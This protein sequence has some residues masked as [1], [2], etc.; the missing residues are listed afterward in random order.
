NG[1]AVNKA[2]GVS[3]DVLRGTFNPIPNVPPANF[4]GRL[5]TLPHFIVLNAA[6]RSSRL[7]YLGAANFDGRPHSVVSYANEDGL[8]TSLYI[9]DKTGLLSK[10]EFMMTDAFAG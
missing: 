10:Y 2:E 8:E 6:E 4:R 5:R 9:D 1:F 7:R 3:W